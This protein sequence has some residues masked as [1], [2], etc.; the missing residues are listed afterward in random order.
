MWEIRKTPY[1]QNE[2]INKVIEII[3]RNQEEILDLKSITETKNSL[4]AFN[5]RFRKAEERSSRLEDRTIETG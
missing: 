4:V 5:S 3:K 2:A 1:E